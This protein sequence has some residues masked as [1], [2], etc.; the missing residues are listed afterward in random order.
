MRRGGLGGHF[1]RCRRGWVEFD[2]TVFQQL[3]RQLAGPRQDVDEGGEAWRLGTEQTVDG[4]LQLA[5]GIEAVGDLLGLLAQVIGVA[6][7]HGTLE[8]FGVDL[9]F[10][11]RHLHSLGILQGEVF[12]VA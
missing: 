9:A 10:V 11:Q 1:W 12:H 5:T 6:Q 3:L 4:R 7:Y 2:S 8:D